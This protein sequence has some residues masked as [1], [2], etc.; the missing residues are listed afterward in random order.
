MSQFPRYEIDL[1]E[2]DICS[3]IPSWSESFVKLEDAIGKAISLLHKGEDGWNCVIMDRESG[4]ELFRL[5]RYLGLATI[6]V[7]DFS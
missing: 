3:D 7:T 6:T 1:V 4:A 2:G 5:Q